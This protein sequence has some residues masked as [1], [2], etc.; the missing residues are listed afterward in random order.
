MNIRRPEKSL[1]ADPLALG[2]M[3]LRT[4]N[5]TERGDVLELDGRTYDLA[6]TEGGLHFRPGVRVEGSGSKVMCRWL[7]QLQSQFEFSHESDLRDMTLINSN[8][9]NQIG[10]CAGFSP[11]V[12][13][14]A[15]TG[16][17]RPN[18][19]WAK[20]INVNL[21]GREYT[22]WN[23]G[24]VGCIIDVYGGTITAGKVAA[25]NYNSSG[26]AAGYLNLFGTSIVVDS[27]MGTVGGESGL[28]AIGVLGRGGTTRAIN[29]PISV[30]GAPW[31]PEADPKNP[32]TITRM[33]GV[34]LGMADKQDAFAPASVSIID[35]P[36]KVTPFP[37]CEATDLYEAAGN[38]AKTN[39]QVGSF[40]VS[41][42]S[43]SG[44]GGK[45]TTRGRVALI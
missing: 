43:G 21:V 15:K 23:C 39:K 1:M 6:D 20:L 2:Q 31:V 16:Y 40:R 13:A 7:Y 24:A 17:V 45:F 26:L 42:G 33:I 9:L 11:C 27:R 10:V 37:G 32:K 38:D 35:C 19:A 4:N 30:T 3:L 36:I 8:Q 5:Q 14:A 12:Y 28:Q 44:E 25:C 41:G 22:L 18:G 29:C 34:Y